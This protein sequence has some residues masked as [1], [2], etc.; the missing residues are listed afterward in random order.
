MRT[1]HAVR[2][3]DKV[4]IHHAHMSKIHGD[5]ADE[6]EAQ[7]DKSFAEHHANL[8]NLHK[9]ASRYH[10]ELSQH[11][12]DLAKELRNGSEVEEA[13]AESFQASTF[14]RDFGLLEPTAVRAVGTLTDPAKLANKIVLRP[15]Q[16]LP[17]PFSPRQHVGG[18]V[19]TVVK[20]GPPP[21]ACAFPSSH[22]LQRCVASCR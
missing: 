20:K 17:D 3:L 1:R 22:V 7:V 12:E 15:G 9:T 6:H 5:L 13:N 18:Y 2:H 10:K 16:E 11:C 8:A 21:L 19:S 4:A 14:D